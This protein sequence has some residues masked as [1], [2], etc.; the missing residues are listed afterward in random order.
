MMMDL[1]QI[2]EV[3][4]DNKI[5]VGST[6]ISFL[7]TIGNSSEIPRYAIQAI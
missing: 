6:K 7:I 2:E 4:S 5:S 1:A 3:F